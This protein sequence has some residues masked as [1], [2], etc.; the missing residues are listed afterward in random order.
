MEEL[1]IRLSWSHVRSEVSKHLAIIGKRMKDKDGTTL[2]AN[3]TLSAEEK[4]IMTQYMNAAAETFS[5]ELSP[6]LVYY[7]SKDTLV[8]KVRNLRWTDGDNGVTVPFEGNFIGYVNA[9]VA[10][11]ILGMTYPELA[12][13]YGEDMANHLSAAI[14][15][16]YIKRQPTNSYKTLEDMKGE[17]I[18]N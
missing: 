15:L 3:V 18:L 7:N 17:V 12:K 16:I 1:T 8:F 4:E 14:K 10:N 9:Y 11:A 13:K 5:A 2:F 6:L